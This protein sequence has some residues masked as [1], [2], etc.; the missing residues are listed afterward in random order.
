LSFSRLNAQIRRELDTLPR[1]HF[2]PSDIVWVPTITEKQLKGLLEW[3]A[4]FDAAEAPQFLITLVLPPGVSCSRGKVTVYDTLQ[5]WQYRSLLT[6]RSLLG[7]N[8]HFTAT[9]LPIA[10]DY[11]CLA[12][13]PIP[14]HPLLLDPELRL[15]P[16]P[17][18]TLLLYAGD[19]IA[20][21]GMQ[22]VP[23]TLQLLVERLPGWKFLVHANDTADWTLK[24]PV[25]ALRAL[26]STIPNFELRTG[27][28]AP[29]EHRL[30]FE[31]SS[32][33]LLGYDANSYRHALSGVLW[34]AIAAGRPLIL[35][36][37]TYVERD[38]RA[39]RANYAAIDS[40]SAERIAERVVATLEGGLLDHDHAFRAAEKFRAVNGVEKFV[41]QLL[42]LGPESSEAGTRSRR[43]S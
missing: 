25:D 18:R 14:A 30:L 4:A 19:A 35:P 32:V 29:A 8:V 23:E 20:R 27:F 15:T 6:N 43:R 42:G 22:W 36:A 37:D 33:V 38:A 5:A 34:E 10:K 7:P 24:A 3:I 2:A 28:L 1:S 13:R 40:S 21:K 16:P 11:S 26:Q 12:K 17:D 31:Q 41:E 39:W 9:G